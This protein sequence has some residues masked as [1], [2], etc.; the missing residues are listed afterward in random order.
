MLKKFA[1]AATGLLLVFGTITAIKAKQFAPP[2]PFEM[3]PESVTTGTAQAQ[4]WEH[5]ITAVGSLRADQGVTVPSE[6]QG[7]VKRI[8]FES[9]AVVKAGDILLELDSQ[10]EQ[11][12]LASAQA[13]AE[14]LRV[15]LERARE[16]WGR[17][18]IAKSDYDSAEAAYKQ[19]SADVN[20]IQATLDKKTMRAPFSGRTGIRLVNLGQ[21]LDRGNPIVSLQ[22]L[23]PI[24]ADFSLPQQRVSEVKVGYTV[25]VTL[26][27]RPGLVFTGKVTAIS[28]EIDSVSRT[29][30]IETTLANADEQLSPGMFVNVA[31]LAPEKTSVVAI[32]ATAVYYQPFGDTVFVVKEQKDEKT[33]QMVQRAEQ[34]FVKLGE[35]RGDFVRVLSGI[36]AGETVVTSGVFKLSNGTKLFVDNS[37]APHAE[38]APKP[39]NS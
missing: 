18:A 27:A 22:A 35:A 33:G 4:E 37:L 21:F 26:D 8:A 16:L 2:P 25:Q 30:R 9:G 11:A 38:L 14:L 5:V 13:R 23:D 29:A 20:S 31:V 10:V 34:R 19:A 39:K 7:T 6:G 32:P 36:A 24:H 12:Q 3:P 28:P 15:N 17:N 1:I